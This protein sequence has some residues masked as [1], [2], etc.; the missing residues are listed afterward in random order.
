LT[1]IPLRP[2]PV[3]ENIRHPLDNLTHLV[4]V[5]ATATILAMVLT[6]R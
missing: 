5:K 2:T 4:F 1:L 6:Y 3:R